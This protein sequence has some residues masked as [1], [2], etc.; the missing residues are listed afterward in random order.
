MSL[1]PS[2]DPDHD[3]DYGVTL[4]GLRSGL[5]V[6]G[7]YELIRKLGQGGMG[8][9]WLA[10]DERLD[11]EVALKFLPE[12]LAQD[13][14]ALDDLRRETRRCMKLNHPHIVRVY[15]L[16]EGGENDTAAIAMEYV[17]GKSLTGLRLEKPNRVFE[18]A[19]LTT[20]IRQ[21]CEA[22]EYAHTE[23]KVVHRDLKPANL[24]VDARGN[25]RVMD[26]GIA[27]SLGDSMSHLS[28]AQS[29]SGGGTLPYMSPQQLMGC[30]PNVSDDVYSLGATIYELLTGK[31]PFFRGGDIGISRQI[32]TQ[33][34]PS[35]AE[36]RK[37]LEVE[38]EAEIPAM[39]EQTVSACLE[40]EG[41][42][43]PPTL[44]S[45]WQHISEFTSRTSLKAKPSKS[46]SAALEA[47]NLTPVVKSSISGQQEPL[48][49]VGVFGLLTVLVLVVIIYWIQSRQY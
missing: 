42:K 34:P 10:H 26:F 7:R 36:R 15:D 3:L 43:R 33:M 46:A 47:T 6:F 28:K 4:R 30:P 25:I 32:E 14:A 49:L 38:S 8:V 22:L 1:S 16:V 40:K 31:P 27:S 39:W 21:V 9:V 12:N 17:E 2:S 41:Q 37:E 35:M 44:A 20:W 19:D 5:K 24:M 48:N 18:V 29:R 45:L 23:G 11:L 13:E